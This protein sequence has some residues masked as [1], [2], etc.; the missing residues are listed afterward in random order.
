MS[1]LSCLI[2]IYSPLPYLRGLVRR[3]NNSVFKGESNVG[4]EV[5]ALD[6]HQCMIS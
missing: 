4:V 2:N 1:D 6:F 3:K 5:R